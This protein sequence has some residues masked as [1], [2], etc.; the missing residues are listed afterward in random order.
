MSLSRE[1]RDILIVAMANRAKANEVA[2]AIDAASV[3]SVATV[4][5]AI[6]STNMTAAVVAATT[7][8]ASAGTFVNA[9]EPTGAE[10][11]T[12]IDE[13]TAKVKAVVDIKADNADLETLRTEAEGRLDAIETKINAV[14]TS[15]KAAGVMAS[16]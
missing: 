9:A 14:L 16:A 13:A 11:D 7:F 2:D 5:A 4:V 6:S 15:L 12:A 1:A 3:A 8:T 10:I